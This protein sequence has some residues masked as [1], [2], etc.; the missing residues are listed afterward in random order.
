MP[1]GPKDSAPHGEPANEPEAHVSDRRRLA[2]VGAMGLAAPLLGFL[3]LPSLV[4]GGMTPDGRGWCEFFVFF[5]ALF[6]TGFVA[7]GIAAWNLST[8]RFASGLAGIILGVLLVFAWHNLPPSGGWAPFLLGLAAAGY[9]VGYG[10]VGSLRWLRAAV[11]RRRHA[12]RSV[13]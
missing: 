2:L 13:A 9:L 8:R 1:D 10:V 7:G 11:A 3:V 12:Q 6:L 5:P 4:C